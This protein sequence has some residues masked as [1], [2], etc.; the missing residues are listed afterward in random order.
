MQDGENDQRQRGHT[1]RDQ[2]STIARASAHSQADVRN[3][4]RDADRQ[5][6]RDHDVRAQACPEGQ[7]T[8][9]EYNRPVFEQELEQSFQRHSDEDALCRHAMASRVPTDRPFLHLR[10]RTQR[11]WK[12]ADGA[13]DPRVL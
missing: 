8:F 13:A 7:P 4:R 3:Q 9:L 10:E 5:G 1:Q 6:D 11:R 12:T 2:H